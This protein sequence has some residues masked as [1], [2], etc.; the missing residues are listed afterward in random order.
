MKSIKFM[1][2]HKIKGGERR[3]GKGGKEMEREGK[4]KKTNMQS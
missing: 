2:T 1:H 3:G 4:E